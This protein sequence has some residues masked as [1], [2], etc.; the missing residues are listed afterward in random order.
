MAQKISAVAIPGHRPAG[1]LTGGTER[2]GDVGPIGQASVQG[3]EWFIRKAHHVA[4]RGR[5]HPYFLASDLA[6]G[7]AVGMSLV[8]AQLWG[9]VRWWGLAVPM[10]LLHLIGYPLYLRIKLKVVKT[11]AR[12]F[13]QDA[14]LLIIPGLVLMSFALGVSPRAA[15]DYL[16]LTLPVMLA[17]YRVGCLVGGC[18][19]G[20]A[21][22]RGIAYRPEH[23]VMAQTRWRRFDPGP[24]PAERVFPLQ[25]VDAAANVVI[26]LSLLPLA[27]DT[28]K[29]PA[30]SLLLLYLAGY[31][32]ARLLLDSFRGHR[33]RP[34]R[35]RLSEAQWTALVLILLAG[36][37]M[38]LAASL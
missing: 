15:T 35:R 25:L 38:G 11:A 28:D 14:V 6:L 27:L 26:A 21:S 29:Q 34:M 33:H 17:I 23:V 16:G 8:V 18:C 9:G 31:S 12:S 2:H 5:Y 32:T 7:A 13:L 20:R 10:V 19:F 37:W 36:V 24:A 1:L 3:V 4:R 22:A 30:V